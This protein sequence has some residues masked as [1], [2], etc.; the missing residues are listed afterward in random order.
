MASLS[1][2]VSGAS[3]RSGKGLA[4]RRWHNLLGLYA[5]FALIMVDGTILYPMLRAIRAELGI[6]ASGASWLIAGYLL[7]F[8][9]VLGFGHR[10]T[11]RI[12]A[13]RTLVA[14]AAL[15]ALA[16]AVAV[17]AWST[18]ALLIARVLQGTAAAF[19]APALAP[20]L[21]A[22]LRNRPTDR[23]VLRWWAVI[24]AS[25]GTIGLML[26][27]TFAGYL[28][29]RWTFAGYLVVAVCVLA[30]VLRQP[31][32]AHHGHP[33]QR[34]P[35]PAGTWRRLRRRGAAG[36]VAL[37]LLVGVSFDGTLF[38]LTLYGQQVLGY[39]PLTLALA[40][41]VLTLT[42]VAGSRVAQP[43]LI[44]F[45]PRAAAVLG[46]AMILAGALVLLAISAPGSFAGDMLTGALLLGFGIGTAFAVAQTV[47]VLEAGKAHPLAENGLADT[48]FALGGATGLIVL[49]G[50]V[51]GA[52]GDVALPAEVTAKLRTGFGVVAAAAA[53]CAVAA[54]AL[55]PGR[56]A[57][58][59]GPG[60]Q[61]PDRV[62]EGMRIEGAGTLNGGTGV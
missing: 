57:R 32:F 27:G 29:W 21:Q 11:E 8:A 46:T 53:I 60:V 2:N 12:G 4:P 7:S 19:I 26:G 38:L 20:L 48:T 34:S 49:S 31:A 18:S 47:I 17:G 28:D 42:S 22:A 58:P 36:S 5:G 33:A 37:L 6:T 61:R 39:P 10:V 55:F 13:R 15:F 9:A 50:I 56:S 23:V 3:R 40:L 59:G 52:T 25:G 24:G 35:A 44:R 1:E 14:G 41:T 51:A 30:L 54:L 45:G 43:A 62:G 16:S